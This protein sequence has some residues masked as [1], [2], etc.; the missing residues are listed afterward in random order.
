MLKIKLRPNSY[1]RRNGVVWESC[2]PFVDNSRAMLIHRPRTVTVYTCLGKKHLAVGVWCGAGFTGTDKFT[3]HDTMNGDKLLC[4]RCEAAA[5]KVGMPS[6]DALV[7]HHVHQ[8]KVVAVQT[9]CITDG[10]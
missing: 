9:C 8:G 2:A 6:A 7:G 5:V 10:D 4:H 3:F 1:Q